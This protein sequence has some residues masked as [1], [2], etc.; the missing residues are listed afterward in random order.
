M[1]EAALNAGTQVYLY[2]ID[3]AILGVNDQR[4]QSLRARGLNLF[5]CAYAAQRRRLPLGETAV[6]SG[7]SVLNELIA[8]TDRFVSFN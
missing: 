6:F 5:A 8:G 1:A 7:L 2:C 4:L 3:A